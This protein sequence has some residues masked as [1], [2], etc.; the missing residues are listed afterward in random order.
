[1]VNF[2][3]FSKGKD[4]VR[5]SQPD[6]SNPHTSVVFIEDYFT[7][8]IISTKIQ[9]L[10]HFLFVCK[11]YTASTGAFSSRFSFVP[12]IFFIFDKAA[13][14]GKLTHRDSDTSSQKM[15]PYSEWKSEQEI[16]LF[17]YSTTV[18]FYTLFLQSISVY[19]VVV[20]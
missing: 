8:Y 16:N 4:T 7:Q 20:R 11:L 13:W 1:M 3:F 5:C 12:V 15:T 17:L 6:T 18:R 10:K 14:T 19:C 9:A 2:L